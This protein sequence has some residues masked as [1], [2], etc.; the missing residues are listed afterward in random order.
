MAQRYAVA[1]ECRHGPEQEWGGIDGVKPSL[2]RGKKIE[3]AVYAQKLPP[4]LCE[5][6]RDKT[7]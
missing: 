5:L 2:P 7:P 4:S 3:G 1:T 6:W